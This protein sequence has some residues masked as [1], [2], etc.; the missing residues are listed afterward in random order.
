MKYNPEIFNKSEKIQ[1]K[2]EESKYGYLSCYMAFWKRF[3]N[4]KQWRFETFDKILQDKQY[5][6]K[7]DILFIPSG[8]LSLKVM[9]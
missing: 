1:L 9:R 8:K 4:Y 7:T 3:K 6:T 5:D 2:T